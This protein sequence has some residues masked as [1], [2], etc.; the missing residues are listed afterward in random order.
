MAFNIT[1]GNHHD[2]KEAANLLKTLDGLAFGDKG[3]MG[4]KW[5]DERL[6]GGLKLMTRKRKNR[7]AEPLS[8]YEKQRLDQRGIVETVIGH[9]K[10]HDQIWHTR[11]RSV[12][13][14]RTHLVCALAA[15]ALEPLTLSTIKLLATQ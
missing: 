10:H 8:D 13:N 12:I 4:K 1:P 6:E 3:Y 5:F 2:G 15:Y 11:H 9:L 7:K 14:A